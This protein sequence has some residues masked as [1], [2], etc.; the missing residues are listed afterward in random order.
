MLAECAVDEEPAPI[1]PS[2]TRAARRIADGLP[3][4]SQTGGC[5]C[6]RGFGSI[7]RSEKLQVAP[8]KLALGFVQNSLR[9]AIASSR[10]APRPVVGMPRP[11]TDSSS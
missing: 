9:T 6:L 3:P 1:Q 7:G 4:P 8:W 2:A 5:G 10:R 11:A